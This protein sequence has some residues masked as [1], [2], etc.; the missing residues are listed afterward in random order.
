[1]RLYVTLAE[2]TGKNPKW[3]TLA[4]PSE[5]KDVHKKIVNDLKIKEGDDKYSRAIIFCNG[6]IAKKV[7]FKGKKYLE[8]KKKRE[9]E[10]KKKAEAAAKAAE[11]AEK[12][13]A[14]EADKKPSK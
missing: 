4:T 3:E 7:N 1:M 9:A 10:A 12:A 6:G 13:K 8:E 14:K 2:T 11:K 5:T